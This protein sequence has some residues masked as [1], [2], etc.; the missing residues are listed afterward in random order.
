MLR[1]FQMPLVGIYKVA[2]DLF[3]PFRKWRSDINKLER[4]VIQQANTSK[5]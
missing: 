4:Y 2:Y 3:P 5:L 1:T